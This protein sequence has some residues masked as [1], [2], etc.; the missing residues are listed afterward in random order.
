MH[1]QR[2]ELEGF[3]TFAKKTVIHFEKG[4]SGVVGSN[5]SGKSNVVDAIKWVLGEQSAKSLRGQAMDDVIFMG[6]EGI[7]AA[8][9]AHV[10]LIF[11]K[12]DEPF[13][14]LFASLDEVEVA[15]R[16]KRSGS[17]SYYL[18]R[19][20]VRLRDV[21]NFF[22]DTGLSNKRYA[23]IEQGQI[24]SIVTA[25]PMQMR[26]LFEEAAGISRFKIQKEGA[27]SKLA[28][29]RDNLIKVSI[30]VDGLEKQLSSLER[31][32]LKAIRHRRLSSMLGQIERSI[33][34]SEY[35]GLLGDRGAQV[36]IYKK[37]LQD[38]ESAELSLKRQWNMMFQAKQSLSSKQEENNRLQKQARDVTK[39]LSETEAQLK[40]QTKEAI[41]LKARISSL[42][43]EKERNRS[44]MVEAEADLEHQQK[45]LTIADAQMKEAASS[46]AL[47]IDEHDKIT[48]QI[49]SFDKKIDE[50]K[51]I[52]DRCLQDKTKLG[53]QI[54]AL[55]QRLVDIRHDLNQRGV[56]VDEIAQQV[57][58][59][60]KIREEWQAQKLVAQDA[61]KKIQGQ[62]R[63]LQ[64]RMQ[65][66][67][68]ELNQQS[69]L[70]RKAG[71]ETQN[72]YRRVIDLDTRLGSLQR[73]A[74]QHEGISQDI[75][76]ILKHPK[77]L[78]T[79]AEHLIV[80]KEKEDL[81][82]TA[83][84]EKI[85]L[86]LVEDTEAMEE[87]LR[88]GKGRVQL[89]LVKKDPV[90]LGFFSDIS[91]EP[92]ALRALGQLLGKVQETNSFSAAI[93]MTGTFILPTQNAVLENGLLQKGR[94]KSS[95]SEIL[96]R[97]RRILQLEEELK[98][99]KE[100]HQALEKIE[101]LALKEEETQRR[102]LQG[103]EQEQQDLQKILRAERER[104]AQISNEI[105]MLLSEESRLQAQVGHQQRLHQRLS[106]E[107]QQKQVKKMEL[108]ERIGELQIKMEDADVANRSVQDQRYKE[109]QVAKKLSQKRNEL[110]IACGTLGERLSQTREAYN[111]LRQ[112]LSQTKQALFRSDEQLKASILRG[113]SLDR[114]NEVLEE[115]NQKLVL[116]QEKVQADLDIAEQGLGKWMKYIEQLEISFHKEQKVKDQASQQRVDEQNKLDRIK[117][118][119]S[120]IHQGMKE[121]YELDLSI[122]LAKI[123]QEG[124]LLF[125]PLD[126]VLAMEP[127]TDEEKEFS[128]AFFLAT[129][130]LENLELIAGWKG[131]VENLQAELG[132]FGNINFMAIQER[133][134]IK[135]E[136][137]LV[138]NQ[139]KDLETSMA[140]IQESISQLEGI[141]SDRFLNT[142]H[143]VD[144]YFQDIYPKLLGGGASRIELEDPEHPLESGVRVWANPPGKKMKILSLLS[145]GEKAQVAIALLFALFRIKP[146]P[147][148]LM[149][150]VDAPLDAA[151]GER[152]NTMLREMSRDSQFIIITH[153]KKT[154]E[155]VDVVYG[156]TIV[157]GV[158]QLVSVRI[159]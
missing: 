105:K 152:F 71:Q 128:E 12:G 136:F 27:E 54:V 140:Q 53:G 2:L 91:G 36:T 82:L 20:K 134:K 28:S 7:E 124:S 75:R 50:Y 62:D 142:V 4:I 38:E 33:A 3:K 45:S 51:S 102:S 70:R 40:Y 114:S 66:G 125:A 113:S 19:S 5:G 48:K 117:E 68:A 111:R 31:Q 110:N 89:L 87:L 149:D 138:M 99:A 118:H 41:D 139:Q 122:L 76:K 10:S 133:L 59:K 84:G 123:E 135:K 8:K 119:V 96:G 24:G 108:E 72:Q 132:K 74:E 14:G 29:T 61:L 95:A 104:I 116:K 158:S 57:S 93:G 77:A 32:S 25:S 78:G 115:Q 15:R 39:E 23:V 127:I 11:S 144:R 34:L 80:P 26:G 156:V 22:L 60:A 88:L 65:A 64:E 46:R 55:K 67:K 79:L 17:S 109:Y 98:I 106:Q 86:V 107:E 147:L 112:G 90:D 56:E 103:L 148:C 13:P 97:H 151:N 141:C 129:A 69:A 81:L 101:E 92:I 155:A 150:E 63:A 126:G 43:A 16:L 146:S 73:L 157:S 9:F 143:G 159:D 154:I 131:T 47:I 83:L 44:V 18:N 85:D 21:Q 130:D 37:S 100:K 30:I 58:E 137:D 42:A 52:S 121:K 94:P 49:R 120:K 153:N 6:A 35:K 145:G 1:I